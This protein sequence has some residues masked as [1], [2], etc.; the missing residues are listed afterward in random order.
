[1]KMRNSKGFHPDRAADRRRD[2][3]HHR[4]DCRPRPAARPHLG[5]RSLGNR[6][7][8]RHPNSGRGERTRRAVAAS[9]YAG[10]LDDLVKVPTERRPGLHQ[11]DLNGPT[12]RDEERL[13]HDP[14]A[15]GG[16]D[17]DRRP[18]AATCNAPT[19]RSPARSKLREGRPGDPERHGHALRS[20]PDTRSTIFQDSRGD[21][22]AEP[23]HADARP[24]RAG[25]TSTERSSRAVAVPPGPTGAPLVRLRAPLTLTPAAASVTTRTVP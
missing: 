1:M 13:P 23:D 15:G 11:P 5:Q 14:A 24:I 19:A 22:H 16:G 6:F 21:D 3:R 10:S 2:H 8:A 25:F 7:A 18:S 4:R 17:S 9:S 12:G 20:R